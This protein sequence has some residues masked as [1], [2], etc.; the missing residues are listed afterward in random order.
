[1]RLHSFQILL[2]E[3]P[4]ETAIVDA[5]LQ[6]DPNVQHFRHVRSSLYEFIHENEE[7]GKVI[8]E[9]LAH[10]EELKSRVTD[11]A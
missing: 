2:G 11:P 8:A 4:P 3:H 10:V 5:M 6:P 1:M 7:R 9:L